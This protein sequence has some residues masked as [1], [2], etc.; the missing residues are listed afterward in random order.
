M[1]W[2]PEGEY[3]A[4]VVQHHAELSATCHLDCLAKV[5]RD[6]PGH[7]FVV[8]FGIANPYIFQRMDSCSTTGH[9]YPVKYN[10]IRNRHEN[11]TT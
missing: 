6:D 3:L 5:K 11:A 9:Q 8:F 1:F 2:V 10:G 4:R 7:I